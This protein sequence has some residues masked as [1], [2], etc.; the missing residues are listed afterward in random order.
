[1]YGRLLTSIEHWFA[2]V[3]EPRPGR[4]QYCQPPE[5]KSG[6]CWRPIGRSERPGSDLAAFV[7]SDMAGLAY[8]RHSEASHY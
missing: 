4:Q 2:K 6:C 5:A 3:G 7:H 1:M 8:L